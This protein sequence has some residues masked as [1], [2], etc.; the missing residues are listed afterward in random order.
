MK[1]VFIGAGNLATNLSLALKKAGFT[2]VQ[3]YSR[4]AKS[5][6]ILA[7][8]T[9]ASFTNNIK[10]IQPDADLYIASIT[11][12]ILSETL[13][14]LTFTPTLLVHTSGS[15]PMNLLKNISTDYGVIYPLQTFTKNKISDFKKIPICIEANNKVIEKKLIKISGKISTQ[16]HVFN[17]EQR[18]KIHLAAVFACN[19]T[20]HMYAVANEILKKEPLSFDLL[21]PLLKET[22]FNALES[23]PFDAQTG[24]A[25][26]NDIKIMAKHNEMLSDYPLFKKIY[27]F[28]SESI[29]RSKLKK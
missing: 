20:N 21:I 2:I 25:I 18:G 24:P 12:D 16:V 13:Q 1:V 28:V 10:K 8:K 15:L 23:S 6:E 22:L 19:F 26:R 7:K 5:S 9:N 29:Y 27:S 11:D 4:T 17:S 14:K 3:I